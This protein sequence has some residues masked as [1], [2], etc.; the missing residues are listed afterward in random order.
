MFDKK[1]AV[2][3]S[4]LL[5]ASFAFAADPTVVNLVTDGNYY[6]PSA[7]TTIDFT[8]ADADDPEDANIVIAYCTDSVSCSDTLKTEIVDGN[9]MDF[10]SLP[11]SSTAQGC[12]YTWTLPTGL[13]ANYHIDV[14]VY[15]ITTIDD[16]NAMTTTTVYIDTNACDT[17]HTISNDVVT[18]VPTCVGY[19]TDANGGNVVTQYSESRQGK[20]APNYSTYTAPF[21]LSFGE[22]TVC[23][24]TT[25]GIGNTEATVGLLHTADSDA[26][27]IALLTELALAALFLFI[28]A[29]YLAAKDQLSG[30]MMLGLV[31]AGVV[32]A[33]SIYIFAVVL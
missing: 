21:G 22:H 12:S 11:L 20:C 3:L 5:I 27:N 4:F 24:Y 17:E 30:P 33:I 19:G 9:S 1:I 28:A 29:G 16:A 31:V 6:Y 14:N 25:D 8:V 32:I 2:I 13:D 7:T 15:D 23:Y 26:Y 10:C 18:L